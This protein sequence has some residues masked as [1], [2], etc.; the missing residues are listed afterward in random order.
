MG[1]VRLGV[2]PSLNNKYL[3]DELAKSFCKWFTLHFPTQFFNHIYLDTQSNNANDYIINNVGELV[4][5]KS[6]QKILQPNLRIT[7]HQSRNNHDEVFGSLW[8][9]NQQPGAHIIDT[10]LTGYRPI[11]YDPY[12]VILAVNEYTIRQQVEIQ[13]T[14][15]T[16]SDQLAFLN[17][18]DS[19]VKNLYVDTF[20]TDTFIPL[21]TLLLEYLRSSIFKPEITALSK[22][23]AE[24][25]ERNEYMQNINKKFAEHLFKFSEN[26]IKP[27]L[28]NNPD[29]MKTTDIVYQYLQ[30][31]LVT[32]HLDKA[33]ADDGDRKG[34]IYSSFNVT[35]SGW[36]EFANPVS[37]ITSVPAI[38]RG[39]K[40]DW[41]LKTSNKKNNMLYYDTIQFK[42]V[43]KDTRRLVQVNKAY[44]QQFYFE[45]E[46]LMSSKHESFDMI[47]EIVDVNATPTHY[48]ILRALLDKI[49]T[50]EE[51]DKLFKV[52]IYKKD[53]PLD[54]STYTIDEKFHFE[55]DNCDLQ[56]PYYIEVFVN[57]LQYE[58]YKELI[59]KDLCKIGYINWD[60]SNSHF[61]RDRNVNTRGIYY[62]PKV[63]HNLF[64]PIKGVDFLITD[65]QFNYYVQVESG[66]FRKVNNDVVLYNDSLDYYIFD[67]EDYVHIDRSKVLIPDPKFDYYIYDKTEEAYYNINNLTEF[68]ILQQY[69]ILKDQMKGVIPDIKSLK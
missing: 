1:T 60:E 9:V 53:E 6:A 44:W 13:V 55:I 45:R 16:K 30:R 10:D 51:F 4:P 47:D 23:I 7:I 11:L 59:L 52:I 24:S 66:E 12:G 35:M 68:D 22:M 14:L 18:C 63:E 19:N 37:F 15:Q 50:K 34:T 61:T 33:E 42:E 57:K 20:K 36:I 69:Y 62:V 17:M 2:F 31:Q 26:H 29:S 28:I 56:E 49:K 27:Y 64:I 40:N 54:S 3:Q 67:G 43:F 48:Y 38:I 32:L 21:P 46:L 25:D 58:Y 5:V 39:Y 65:P 8:N 41:Y